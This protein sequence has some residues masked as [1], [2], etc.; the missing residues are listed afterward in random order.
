MRLIFANA[1]PYLPDNTS[2]REISIHA[3]AQRFRARGIDVAVFAERAGAAAPAESTTA[4]T[5]DLDLGYP[6]YRA[7][8]THLGY[9][10]ALADWR[11]GIAIL[12]FGPPSMPLVALG[13]Q[14]GVKAVLHVTSVEP[15]DYATSPVAHPGIGLIA[16][17]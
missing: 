2:G 15:H 3:L 6:V 16:N 12:P 5:V 13:L 10:A 7:P 8:Q 17:S 14:A 9:Q 1:H 11:P 4:Y